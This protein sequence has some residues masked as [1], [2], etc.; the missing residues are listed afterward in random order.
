MTVLTFRT[1]LYTTDTQELHGT[2]LLRGAESVS[3]PAR[4]AAIYGGAHGRDAAPVP[5]GGMERAPGETAHM[6]AGTARVRKG[7]VEGLKE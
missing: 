7:R 6:V 2:G 3:G 4:I 1:A 5:D